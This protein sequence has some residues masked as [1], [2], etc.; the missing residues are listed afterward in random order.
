M[1]ENN[2]ETENDRPRQI[3]EKRGSYQQNIKNIEEDI[4]NINS[5]LISKQNKIDE[6]NTALKSINEKKLEKTESK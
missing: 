6:L 3:A 4:K 1:L 2:L 5:N